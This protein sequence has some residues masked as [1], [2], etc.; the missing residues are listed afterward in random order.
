M[1][2]GKKINIWTDSKYAFGVV[3]AHGALWKERGLLTAQGKQ[4]KHAKEILQLLEAINLPEQVAIM[5]CRGHQKGNTEQELGNKLADQEAK[6][7]AERSFVKT[8][9]LVPD[10]ELVDTEMEFKYSKEDMKLVKD[11]GAS[12]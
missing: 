10:G 12:E 3:H 4:I 2:K 9:A 1:A 11:L 6:R 7:A 5:H 8:L